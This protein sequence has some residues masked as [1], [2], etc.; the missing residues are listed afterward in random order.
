MNITK[1]IRLLFLI[2]ILSAVDH[3]NAQDSTLFLSPKMFNKHQAIWLN[4]YN[5]WLY[6]KG[7]DLA[8]ANLKL[9]TSGWEHLT[10]RQITEKMADANGVIEGWFRIK[11][12]ADSSLATIPLYLFSLFAMDLHRTLIILIA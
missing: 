7:N 3:C 8:W 1:N 12:N 10:P 5:V 2:L 6:Q 4:D 11:I 9:N